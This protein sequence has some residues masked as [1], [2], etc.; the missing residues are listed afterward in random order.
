MLLQLA[1]YAQQQPPVSIRWQKGGALPF[2]AGQTR[3]P[4]Y[5]G[6]VAGIS[7]DLLLLA[8]G[9]NF[10]DSMPW[11][12]GKKKYYDEVFVFRNKGGALIPLPSDTKLLFPV[13]YAASCSTPNG[14]FYAGGENSDGISNKSF[15][16]SW[17]KKKKELHTVRLP[18]LPFPVTNAAAIAA[19][20]QVLITGGENTDSTLSSFIMLDLQ[21]IT[22]G[23]KVL[24]SV[25]QPLSHTVVIS[26]TGENGNTQVY[27]MGGRKKNPDGISDFSATVFA[28]DMTAKTWANKPSLPYPL[29]AG[30]GIA[31]G[32][33]KI[34][35]FGGDKGET[36]RKTEILIAALKNETSEVRKQELLHQKI[37]LQSSHPGFDQTVLLYDAAAGECTT[38][39]TLSFETPVTTTAFAW[40]DCFVIPSGEI[41]A[42]V[43]TPQIRLGKIKNRRSSAS[44]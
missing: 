39:G 35:L 44:K 12:G 22:A 37:Q 42:G 9:A 41:R 19:G 38:A 1:S 13:A 33:D 17:N 5:A 26:L 40:D 23:W 34:I 8:G 21:N 10:P 31:A 18:D 3:S 16:L 36:F 29:S 28:Y 27:L 2:L 25:P 43:R 20:S 14:V 24:P 30:T 6:M 4:G 32:K 15:L 7:N 11:L